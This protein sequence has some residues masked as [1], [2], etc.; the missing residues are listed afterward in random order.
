MTKTVVMKRTDLVD[1]L[2]G[3]T[4]RKGKMLKIQWPRLTD[5]KV[6][7]EIVEA[8]G[9]NVQ[10]R[11]VLRS[12]WTKPTPSGSFVPKGGNMFNAENKEKAKAIKAKHNLFL[13]MSLEGVSHPQGEKDHPVNVPLDRVN[14]IEDTHEKIVYRVVE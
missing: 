2:K 7:G 9:T 5:K 6:N 10:R 8:K 11:L 12:D 14:E 1:F 13:F 3:D 4:L